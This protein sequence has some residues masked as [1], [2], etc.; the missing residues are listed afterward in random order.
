MNFKIDFCGQKLHVSSGPHIKRARPKFSIEDADTN[1]KPL[2]I[3]K[4]CIERTIPGLFTFKCEDF[5][6][7]FSDVVFKLSRLFH[8]V[9]LTAGLDGHRAISSLLSYSVSSWRPHFYELLCTGF[10]ILARDCLFDYQYSAMRHIFSFLFFVPLF[11]SFWHAM[12]YGYRLNNVTIYKHLWIATVAQYI[13]TCF[14]GHH[15]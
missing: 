7:L 6:T 14:G 12:E 9:A 3:L 13:K 4:T 8:I 5:L 10:I 2:A 11:V 1:I 15:V